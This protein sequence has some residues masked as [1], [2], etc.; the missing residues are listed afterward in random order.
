MLGPTQTKSNKKTVLGFVIGALII[1]SL[2]EIGIVLYDHFVKNATFH[3][4][5]FFKD[6]LAVY[7][8]SD[9]TGNLRYGLINEDGEIVIEAS[10]EALLPLGE[11]RVAI[12]E[13]KNGTS[14]YGIIT[15][16]G[17]K[18]TNT[19]YEEIRRYSGKFLAAKQKGKWGFVDTEGNWVI[20][21]V[22]EDVHS[23]SEGVASVKKG[24]KWFFID[25]K[26]K[27]ISKEAFEAA[28]NLK[29]G[30]ARV[31]KDGKWG[32]I[33]VNFNWLV[34]PQYD[35]A[36]DFSGGLA[37]VCK[38][39]KWGYID[40][41]FKEVIPPKFKYARNFKNGLAA[42]ANANGKYGYISTDG[43]AI[44]KYN[45]DYDFAGDFSSSNRAAIYN[46]TTGK[47][48][49]ITSGGKYM[50]K[51]R[52]EY[53]EEFHKNLAPVSQNGK[54]YTYIDIKGTNV[55]KETYAYISK[56][57]EDGYSIIKTYDGKWFAIN[58]KG[59]PLSDEK[60]ND[61]ISGNDL[62]WFLNQ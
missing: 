28:G 40:S 5:S 54:D 62:K 22:Y 2:I 42:V 23:F 61:L 27:M 44:I 10:Y 6:E 35:A 56:F 33:D 38:N 48:N 18:I 50:G 24:G 36:R 52:F 3:S 34:K 20:K 55:L 9:K 31:K 15:T 51:T 43:K 19:K 60:Y 39:G 32:Y 8:K 4:D 59:V 16:E 47:W 11:D 53:A 58:D 37:A 1:F 49:Y 12:K 17:K 46:K 29:R 57:Y 30:I 26:S 25:K 45:E 13:T 14:L 41:E 21:P 7:G